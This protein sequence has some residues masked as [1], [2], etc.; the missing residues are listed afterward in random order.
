MNFNLFKIASHTVCPKH[1]SNKT[2]A[3]TLAEVLITLGIIGIIANMTIPTL[4]ASYQKQ[5]YVTQL[6]KAYSE[7]QTGIQL[8]MTNQGCSDLPCTGIFNDWGSG[9]WASNI[10]GA[11][12]SSF[13]IIKK[14]LPGDNSCGKN[15]KYL[16]ATPNSDSGFQ[17]ASDYVFLTADN[18]LFQI[19]DG[20]SE[21]CGYYSTT[22]T[23]SKLK[24]A[25]AGVLID[26]NG[27]SMP[28]RFGRDVFFFTLSE[29]GYLFP[30]YGSDYAKAYNDIEDFS[31]SAFYWQKQNG[32]CGTLNSS[33][34]INSATGYGCAARVMD[35]GWEMNY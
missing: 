21:N 12:S 30:D 5:V 25:C 31:T 1:R 29:N 19:N 33:T 23:S 20:R 32:Y 15:I 18:F 27:N 14:C 9:F 34:L 13:K 2:F 28:N 26:V 6:K 22:I 11:M 4:I 10:D 7:F 35:E 24:N 17:G 16:G 8:Y 3:F